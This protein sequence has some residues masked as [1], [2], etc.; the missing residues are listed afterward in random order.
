M[1]TIFNA[2]GPMPNKTSYFQG[3][4]GVNEPTPK[5]PKYKKE[6]VKKDVTKARGLLF[7]NYDL[8]E[9]E[10]VN[11]PGKVKTPG[12]GLYQNM[13]KYKSVSDFR[14]KKRKA[15]MLYRKMALLT[16]IAEPESVKDKEYEDSNNI[17]ANE[18]V[19]PIPIS[20]AEVAPIG[21]LDGI[22]PQEDLDGKPV[23][24]LYYGRMETHLSDDGKDKK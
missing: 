11:G 12:K 14:K 5:K 24:N 17:D 23:S 15:P 1:P 13:D 6:P 4:G 3:G 2:R 19:T 9:T 7:K 16:A 18:D 10:G 8:Y 21:M 22:Y 20:P